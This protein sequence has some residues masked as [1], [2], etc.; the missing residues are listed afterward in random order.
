[1]ITLTV[2]LTALFI[3][4]PLDES[5]TRWST[6]TQLTNQIEKLDK[7]SELISVSTL[8]F[9]TEGLPIQCI[10]VARNGD[11][12]IDERSAILLVAGIDGTHVLGSEVA[13]ELQKV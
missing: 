2:C 7:S 11:T 10:Q 3:Y 8:G 6:P 13:I 12:P 4:Q 9:S 5:A 1:M